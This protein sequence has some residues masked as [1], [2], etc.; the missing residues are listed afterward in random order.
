[1]VRAIRLPTL[2]AVLAVL[3]LGTALAEPPDRPRKRHLEAG[4]FDDG[5]VGMRSSYASV[6]AQAHAAA[7]ETTAAGTATVVVTTAGRRGDGATGVRRAS[8]RTDISVTADSRGTSS[9]QGTTTVEAFT[10]GRSASGS[11]G[12]SRMRLTSTAAT[13]AE[14]AGGT[15]MSAIGAGGTAVAGDAAASTAATGGAAGGPA[16]TASGISLG[17]S[18]RSGEAQPGR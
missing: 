3:G 12:A 5:G 17:I 8:S 13:R 7:G 15:A 6:S 4:R 11:A 2:L 10:A 16:G 1:M 9:G 18:A 14:A